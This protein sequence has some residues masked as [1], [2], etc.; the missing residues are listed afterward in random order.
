MTTLHLA[1]NFD[2][3]LDAATRRMA[4]LA[5]SGAGKSNV[6]VVLAEQMYAAGIPW[7]AIDPKGDWYGVRSSKSGKGPG[8]PIPIF[9]G[10]HG[11]IP[12]E[13]TAGKLIG[14]L[15]VAQRLTCVLDISEFEDRQKQW[16]FLIDL[17]E[18]LL[19]RNRQ[20]LH[21]F[22]EE[23]D[24]YLPQRT[25]EKGNL[26]K[27]LGVWQRVV[28][29]GR[30]RGIGSTQITQRNA[31]LNKDTLYM[32]EA[33]IAMRVTGKA[34]REAVRGWVEYNN[35]SDEI[36]AS[37]PTLRDGEGWVSSPAWLRL[38]ERVQFNRRQTFDSGSTPIH[39]IG[40]SAPP[41]TLADVDL[42]ALK[43]E[44]AATIEKAKA[45]DP[46]ELRKQIDALRKENRE[47]SRGIG[48]ATSGKAILQM[49]DQA[50]APLRAK[51]RMQSAVIDS[52]RSA[53][54]RRTSAI[55]K[56]CDE[57]GAMARADIAEY[58]TL[59]NAAEAS[60]G[61]VQLGNHEKGTGAN[62]PSATTVR[63]QARSTTRPTV[64]HEGLSGVEQK[65][66]NT[67]R[68]LEDLGVSP[69][70]KATCAALVG[71]HPNAKSYANALGALR[72][73]GRVNYPAGG[74][75]E[76]TDDGRAV[77][78]SSLA[79]STVDELHAVWIDKL[80]NVAEKILR[81]LLNVYPATV[82]RDA[83]AEAAGYH[84]NAKSFANMIGRLRTLGLIDYP[85]KGEVVATK[86]LFPE[87]LS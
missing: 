34:D 43:V 11:D 47:L 13:P 14:E 58:D 37:L 50:E 54:G 75:V 77:S 7:V 23:A 19:R 61:D 67:L 17:G 57:V 16:G 3:P 6:A 83:L 10:L 62:Q 49:I 20:A 30:F 12:L 9:G 59:K 21:L 64:T 53:L 80:G 56:L 79:V 41:A 39:A 87:G 2:L 38:T 44:M 4:I 35:A 28:K 26:P 24:E 81:P 71:Y 66:L 45:D 29:R 27:C 51:I 85:R 84:P 82:S 78:E 36:A 22:L 69:V 8:L 33:L 15:I 25:S 31:S 63:P 68:G 40:K 1:P 65:I 42:A 74:Q 32:A 76:L 18:T 70:D 72:T 46:T 86:V 5:M 60:R 55:S 52:M 73:S 48:Q